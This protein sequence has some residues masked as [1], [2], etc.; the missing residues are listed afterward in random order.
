MNI[1]NVNMHYGV[2]KRRVADA[3][4]ITGAET[5]YHCCG[6]IIGSPDGFGKSLR[7]LVD[8]MRASEEGMWLAF[9]G[10]GEPGSPGANMRKAVLVQTDRGPFYRNHHGDGYAGNGRA[11]RDFYARAGFY[12]L[13]HI[14]SIW[15]SSAAE[16]SHLAGYGWPPQMA[17]SFLDG[18]RRWI[19]THPDSALRDIY[20][21]DGGYCQMDSAS[22]LADALTAVD[23][24]G[25]SWNDVAVETVDPDVLGVPELGEWIRLLKVDV[26]H[27]EE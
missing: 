18:A 17:P 11:W 24:D 10:I 15:G 14:N 3:P 20:F 23:G 21:R 22:T 9:V 27:E 13:D 12:S 25:S 26:S 4:V 16:V 7:N 6:G 19:L 5:G 8:A 2:D 1:E